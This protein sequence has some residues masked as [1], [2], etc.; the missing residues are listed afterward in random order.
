MG[1]N[2]VLALIL[3]YI[4]PCVHICLLQ[5]M[6]TFCKFFVMFGAVVFVIAMDSRQNDF[7]LDKRKLY[8]H[9]SKE[10]AVTP[11]NV[12]CHYKEPFGHLK[13][14]MSYKESGFNVGIV[15]HEYIVMFDGYYMAQDRFGYISTAMQTLCLNKSMWGVMPRK[16][17]AQF[18]PSDFDVLQVHPS[19]EPQVSIDGNQNSC[20][21]CNDFLNY[22]YFAGNY[23]YVWICSVVCVSK[24]L[25]MYGVQNST[26]IEGFFASMPMPFIFLCLYIPIFLHYS[27]HS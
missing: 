13:M 6:K 9:A 15:P 21:V 8:Y 23:Y 11:S 24:A 16:N 3:N 14:N 18:Y 1:G 20:H 7:P 25:L 4:D 10:D 2:N 27:N 5:K 22:Y 17:L 19:V 12:T 26:N